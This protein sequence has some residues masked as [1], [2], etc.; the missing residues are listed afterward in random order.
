MLSVL[1]VIVRLERRQG[2]RRKIGSLLLAVSILLVLMPDT[3]MAARMER[4]PAAVREETD[5]REIDWVAEEGKAAE[6]EA[7]RAAD[8][9][10]NIDTDK[11]P[12]IFPEAFS[13]P[14]LWG[15]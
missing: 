5:Q 15:R 11:A 3:A 1:T 2:M 8:T 13:A 10:I 6:E 7:D 4:K 9:D 12:E 14:A